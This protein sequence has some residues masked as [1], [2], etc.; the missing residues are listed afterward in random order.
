ME[1]MVSARSLPES[2]RAARSAAFRA[3]DQRLAATLSPERCTTLSTPAS[4]AGSSSPFAGS[5]KAA[6]PPAERRSRTSRR[7]STPDWGE[8]RREGAADEPARSADRDFHDA[9]LI[10]YPPSTLIDWA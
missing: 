2:I 9:Y 6:P 4:A 5:Q 3:A 1:A 7:T 8:R 10:R